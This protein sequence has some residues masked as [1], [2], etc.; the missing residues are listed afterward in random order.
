MPLASGITLAGLIRN[1]YYEVTVTLMDNRQPED[2]AKRLLHR[3]AQAADKL[4]HCH[5]LLHN[6]QLCLWTQTDE[7]NAI[8]PAILKLIDWAEEVLLPTYQPYYDSL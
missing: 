4:E 8:E 7:Q 3:R 1:Q 6:H 5:L 2:F